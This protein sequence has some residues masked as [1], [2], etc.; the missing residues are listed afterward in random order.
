MG[1]RVFEN[2]FKK[3]SISR[4]ELGSLLKSKGKLV[5]L[6]TIKERGEIEVQLHSFI[7]AALGRGK[8]LFLGRFRRYP[9]NKGLPE[10]QSPYGDF[11]EQKHLLFPSRDS[12]SQTVHSAAQSLYQLRYPVSSIPFSI[13]FKVCT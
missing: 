11:G 2:F 8:S 10:L 4:W 7:T 9:P 6:H 12:N 5:P 13:Y 1:L 3:I